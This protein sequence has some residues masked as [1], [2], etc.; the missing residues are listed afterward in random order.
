MPRQD[1]ISIPKEGC[2]GG[3]DTK[4]KEGL[5]PGLNPGQDGREEREQRGGLPG[6]LGKP[7]PPPHREEAQG[8]TCK[9]VGGVE[10][11]Q[12]RS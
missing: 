8:P 10:P 6:G 3:C 9:P 11:S 1:S 2:A 4:P 7:P 12:P 5:G